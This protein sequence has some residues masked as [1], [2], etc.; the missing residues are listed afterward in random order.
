MTA[1][2]GVR[3]TS[4]SAGRKVSGWFTRERMTR[5]NGVLAGTAL[6][7]VLAHLISAGNYGYFRD[8]LYYIAAGRHL[9]FGYVDFPP[10]IAWL[11]A[12]LN[13]IAGGQ[14]GGHS[15]RVGAGDRLR[16]LSHRSDG[17]R[18]GWDAIR[19]GACRHRDG[20]H[21]SIPSHR[22]AFQHGRAR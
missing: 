6:I 8:E 4:R 7:T 17:A 2:D 20:L 22:V 18:A 14:S 11:A 9:A 1:V 16:G 3:T 15:H 21:A 10:M 19:T 12:L 5:D 13:V